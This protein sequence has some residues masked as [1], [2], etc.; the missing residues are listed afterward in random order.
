MT[1]KELTEFK[2]TGTRAIR[3]PDGTSK[4]VR[5]PPEYWETFDALKVIEG[6]NETD[7]AAFAEEEAK[8]QNTSFDRGF[9]CCVAHLANRWTN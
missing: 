8:L 7:I 1:H 9:R 3:M 2:T 6:F 5:M 4:N